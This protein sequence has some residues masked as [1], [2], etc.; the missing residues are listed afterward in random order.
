[1]GPRGFLGD[2]P[3]RTSVEIPTSAGKPCV[4]DALSTLCGLRNF[5]YQKIVN[6]DFA[7]SRSPAYNLVY[8]YELDS[9]DAANILE[10]VELSGYDVRGPDVASWINTHRN[11][12]KRWLD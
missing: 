6:S 9:E 12:W 10:I 5:H 8:K 2:G 1:E 3:G 11:V 7:A 4:R